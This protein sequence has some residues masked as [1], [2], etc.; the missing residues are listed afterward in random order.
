[1]IRRPPRSTLF[2]YTTLFRS[3]IRLLQLTAFVSTFDRFAMP[4][5]L[6]AIALD[7]DIPLSVVVT[8][9]GG[10]LLGDPESTRLD[11]RHANTSHSVFC[12]QKKTYSVPLTLSLLC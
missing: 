11:S 8:A 5:M 10:Y 1:M 4:P 2:P 6:V 9:A 3:P 12:L 7:L